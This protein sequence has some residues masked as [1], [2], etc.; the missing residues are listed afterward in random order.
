MRVRHPPG[1]AGQLWLTERLDLA[2]RATDL[3]VQ[4][5]RVLLREQRRLGVLQRRTK[6]AWETACRDAQT[7][8]ARAA[9]VRGRR[10]M[11]LAGRPGQAGVDLA[12]R[13]SMGA[14]YPIEV[15]CVLPDDR[16]LGGL[17]GTSTATEASRAHR[18]ALECAVDHAATARVRHR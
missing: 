2:R 16:S 17:T 10:V 18:R 6:S 4:K 1:R 8:V 14:Y 7:W 12:W 3:L 15:T 5:E 9:S 11:T 13:N